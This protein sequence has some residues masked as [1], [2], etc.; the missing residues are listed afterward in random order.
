[1][2]SDL[3]VK[4]LR[5]K[6]QELQTAL[7]FNESESPLRISTLMISA[8]AID[9]AGQIWFVVPNHGQFDQAQHGT[10]PAKMDFFKK[11]K[12]FYVKIKGIASVVSKKEDL[13]SQLSGEI[14]QRVAKKQAVLLCVKIQQADYFESTIK[15]AQNWIQQSGSQIFN[16]L[17]NP[18]YDHK[19][20]QLVAIPITLDQ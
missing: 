3:N 9:D 4:F 13:F 12:D 5:E 11:G 15:P 6:V 8:E 20:P 17:L 16:W 14:K 10:F 19:N 2:M 7:F 18:Q 1:M